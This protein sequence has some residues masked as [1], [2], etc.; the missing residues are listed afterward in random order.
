MSAASTGYVV[1]VVFKAHPERRDAFR[2]ATLENAAASRETEPGCSRFD[3]CESADG[4][5]IFL[6]EIYDDEAAFKAHL[7][8]EHFLRFNAL[9]TPWVVEKRVV[10]Y[11]RLAPES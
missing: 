10:P 3:V 7:A 8:T 6:Y 1:T 5:E 2:V 11:L 9:V 4:S